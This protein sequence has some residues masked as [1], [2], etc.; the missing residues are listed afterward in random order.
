METNKKPIAERK[1]ALAACLDFFYEHNNSDPFVFKIK[2]HKNLDFAAHFHQAVELYYIVNGSMDVI[3]NGQKFTVCAGDIFVCNS[4]DVHRYIM[5]GDCDVLVWIAGD[6]FFGEFRN[7]YNNKI[8]ES[9]LRDKACNRKVGEILSSIHDNRTDLS[10]LEKIAYANLVLAVL[11]KNYGVVE[12]KNNSEKIIKIIEYIHTNYDKEL[13]LKD[14]AKEF[15]YAK[16]SF[17]RLFHAN[18]G[19]DYRVFVN[20]VRAEKAYQ[21]LSKEKYKDWSITQIA[22]FCGFN[23]MATFYRAYRNCFGELPVKN[24]GS[25]ASGSTFFSGG[26]GE[27]KI[28]R[29][30]RKTALIRRLSESA[31]FREQKCLPARAFLRHRQ[32]G[33]YLA[34]LL[35]QAA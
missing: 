13:S 3:I 32:I 5:T 17:S 12:K 18:L 8:L 26:G 28:F 4:F 34:A 11:S 35:R 29:K 31:C 30:T 22:S 16:V 15:G 23:S 7:V 2:T 20:S 21:M 14:I 25:V 27:I 9:V 33:T 6:R 19:V 10:L 1:K 24:S